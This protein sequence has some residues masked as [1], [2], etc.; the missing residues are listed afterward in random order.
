M[1]HLI[2]IT[3]IKLKYQSEQKKITAPQLKGAFAAYLETHLKEELMK[4]KIPLDIVYNRDEEGKPIHR[5]PLLQFRTERQEVEIVGIANG[6]QVVNLW[7]EHVL[8]AKDF[9]IN[10]KDI[11]FL[12]PEINTQKWYPQL[13]PQQS[14]YRIS[15]WKPYDSETLGNESRLDGII[16][17]NIHRMLEDLGIQLKG[18]T[19]IHLRSF[20]KRK[21]VKG[22]HI[23]WINYDA[24]FST[25][26]NL[27]QHIGIGHEPSIGSG[28][29]HKID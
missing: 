28:K 12:Y 22:Y 23:N 6:D 24:V 21:P 8:K 26:I 10:G 29:M 20:K 7:V 16:W 4:M 2:P 19:A 15:S 9:Q 11:V 3:Q 5:Y 18:K 17:G 27:P 14:N 13:M 1:N 25:N